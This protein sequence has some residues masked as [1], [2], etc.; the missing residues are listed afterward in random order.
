MTTYKVG[1]VVR[2]WAGRI[3]VVKSVRN[4]PDWAPGVEPRLQRIT[5]E[6]PGNTRHMEGPASSYTPQA[7]GPEGT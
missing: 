1:D 4:Q 6:Y 5:V 3:G 7:P 2:D